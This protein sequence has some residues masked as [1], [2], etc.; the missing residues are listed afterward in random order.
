MVTLLC[1]LVVLLVSA[2]VTGALLVGRKLHIGVTGDVPTHSD[3]KL[4]S[5][6]V[7]RIGGVGIYVGGLVGLVLFTPDMADS[8]AKS[9]WALWGCMSLVFGVGMVEDLTRRVPP[10][11]RYAASI[12]AALMF[13]LA[14]GNLGITGVAIPPVDAVLSF[15]PL[16][17]VFF[18]F[19][20]AGI[21]HAFNLIDGQHG[22]CVGYSILVYIVLA[23]AAGHTGQTALAEFA[24]VMCVANLGFAIFNFPTGSIF[25]GDAGAYF[26]GAIVAVMTVL[27]VEGAPSISPWFA[28]L[29]L[30]YPVSET[31]FSMMRRYRAG[32]HFYQPDCDHLHHRLR[33]ALLRWSVP[34]ANLAAAPILMLV[35][36]FTVAAYFVSGSTTLL[37]ALSL[38]FLM[39]YLWSYSLLREGR[40]QQAEALH[41]VD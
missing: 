7:P 14:I 32:R 29:L 5:A 31:F 28:I 40:L 6:T 38:L 3:H 23:L 17:V 39:L 20:V 10:A 12:M 27:V 36:P 15:T 34:M 9:I 1:I 35:M 8:V 13:S 21:C 26:N 24:L 19:A 25:M 33:R 37:V 18:V 30:I 41:A 22:L 16:S 4:H 11:V 2:A